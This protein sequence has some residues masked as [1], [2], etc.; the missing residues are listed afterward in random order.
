MRNNSHFSQSLLNILFFICVAFLFS[1]EAQFDGKECPPKEDIFPCTCELSEENRSHIVCRNLL[2]SDILAYV[3]KA[4]RGVDIYALS[5]R[6]STLQYL[7]SEEFEGT[8]FEY[9]ELLN[10][11]LLAISPTEYALQGLEKRTYM[12]DIINCRFMNGWSWK[13]FEKFSSLM[14]LQFLDGDL[15]SIS[16]DFSALSNNRL[17]HGINFGNNEIQSLKEDT[18]AMFKDLSSL[19]LQDNQIRRVSRSMLP[20]PAERLFFINLSNNELDSLPDDFFTNMPKLK[21][22]FIS[23]NH[24]MTISQDVFGPVWK[25]DLWLEIQHNNIICDCR[26]KWIVSQPKPSYFIGECSGPSHL[27][28]RKLTTLKELELTC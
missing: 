26:L 15:R 28:G 22:I 1:T 2:R 13:A 27:V 14:V 10:T 20:N 17:L 5:I 24:L 19:Y 6:D 23:G 21:Q 12:I 8:S 16:S 11:G 25:H 4:S 7:P 3:V 18:F 9:I